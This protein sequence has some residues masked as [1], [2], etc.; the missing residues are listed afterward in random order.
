MTNDRFATLRQSLPHIR[1]LLSKLEPTYRFPT[2]SEI[3]AAFIERNDIGVVLWDV[4]GTLMGYH[5]ND[6]DRQFPHIRSLFHHGPARHAILSNC[7]EVRYEQLGRMFS[8][9]PVIRGYRTTDGPVFRHKL[10]RSDT[11]TPEEVRRILSTGGVLMRKPSGDLI[12]YGMTIFEINDPRAV[13]MVGDQYLTDIASA[14]LVG[15]RSAKVPTF[16]RRTFP[17]SIQVSQRVERILYA[18]RTSRERGGAR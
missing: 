6:I 4:D 8:E 1:E 10:A 3:D 11:H 18:F 14:N 15:A 17:L 13:L 2:V 7:D 12:R 9:I 16:K 5:A